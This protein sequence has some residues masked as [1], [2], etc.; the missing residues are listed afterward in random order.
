MFVPKVEDKLIFKIKA[1]LDKAQSTDSQ[2]EKDLFMT[3]AQELIL[4]NNLSYEKVIGVSA[5][6]DSQGRITNEAI[7]ELEISYSEEWDR[8]L[9]CNVS[10]GSFCVP[11]MNSSKGVVCVIGKET[12]ASGVV[13]MCDFYIKAIMNLAIE[14]A[15]KT[16]LT[17]KMIALRELKKGVLSDAVLMKIRQKEKENINDY[18]YGAVDGLNNALTSKVNEFNSSRFSVE[19]NSG[20]LKSVTGMEV[21]KINRDRVQEYINEKYPRLRSYRGGSAGGNSNSSS[22][23]RGFNDGGGLGSSQRR[24]NQGINKIKFF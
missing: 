22:Y 20:L 7:V 2:A 4:K 9:I 11:L 24:L 3:K 14:S 18:L 8:K 6:R 5:E 12:N 21:S 16:T 23:N 15:K 19:D 10:K 1:L 17:N 13:A